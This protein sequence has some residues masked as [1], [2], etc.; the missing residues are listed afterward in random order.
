MTHNALDDD[1]SGLFGL[2]NL[3]TIKNELEERTE[4]KESLSEVGE[5]CNFEKELS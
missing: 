2:R 4:M 1:D 5:N 3:T